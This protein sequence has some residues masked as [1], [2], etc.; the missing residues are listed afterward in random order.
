M[1]ITIGGQDYTSA[2]DA[3]RPLTIERR[4]NEPSVCQLWI[5]LAGTSLSAPVRNQSIRITGDDGTDYFTGYVAATPLPEYAGLGIEGPRYRF[6]VEAISDEYLLDRLGMAPIK[7]S[8]SG[9]AG[10]LLAALAAK[11]GSSTISAGTLSLAA[12]VLSFMP[13]AGASFSASAA[14]LANQSRSAYR[15]LNGA[16]SLSSMPAVVHP[17]T[18][19]DGSLALESLTLTAGTKRALA[20]DITVCG[21]HEPTAYVTEYFLGDGVTTQFNLSAD[22]FMLPAS[23]ATIIQ[24]LFDEGEIDLRNWSNSGAQGYLKLGAGGLSMLGGSG[25][26]GETELTWL[27]TVEMGGTLLLEATGVTLANESAGILAGFFEGG[28]DAA[29]CTAGFQVMAQQGT[30]AVSVQPLVQGAAAG[31]PYAVNSANQYALRVRVHCPESQRGLSVYRSFGDHGAITS[32]GQWNTA[33]AKLQFEIQEFVNGVAGMPVTLYEGEIA[34]LPGTCTVVAADSI[35]LYGSMRSL[36][37]SN[38]GSGWVVTTAP[39]GSSMTRRTGTAAQ[40]AECS[41]ESGGKLVFNPGFA[42]PAGTLIAVS[43]RGV[44][45]SVGRAVNSESQQALAQAGM[46][47]ISRWMGT[48]TNPAPRC[49]QDCRNAASVLEQA[50]ASTSALWSGTYQCTREGLDGDVWP[51]DALGLNVPSANLTAE[52]IVR[53]VKLTYGASYPDQVEYAIEFANDWADDLAIKTSA[54]VP[55]DAW[56]P[57]PVSPTY[58]PNL[59]GLAVTA[60][61]G[62]AVTIDAGT[63]APDGGGFE[64]RRR[65]NCFMPGTD[66]DLVMRSSQPT[67]TFSRVS[68]AD[69]FYIRMYDGAN[70]PNYSEFS[71]ALI[72][73]TPLSS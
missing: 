47:P 43:Y 53:S 27:D 57:A 59:S 31:T 21:E 23:R 45:R 61:N 40:S 32:G 28:Q 25:R 2:L 8:M 14:L 37:L 35:N 69:R 17:L 71:A 65:D 41:F 60:I 13:Q 73:N 42:P 20:N 50:A 64:I 66:S 72:F 4:L 63:T 56:L 26:D 68:A 11:T 36:H 58:A 44:G 22:A 39:G 38:L 29:A 7:G 18:E 54:A 34:T 33:P 48:V 52:V 10:P 5:T 3:V 19:T 70:P 55:E 1:K 62:S 6:A 30:G 46:P 16:L 67:M 49:S 51:G 24:E 12:P 9:N 15:A